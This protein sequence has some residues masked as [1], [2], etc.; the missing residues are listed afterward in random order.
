MA[1]DGPFPNELK[2]PGLET[3]G[4][5]VACQSARVVSVVIP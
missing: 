4:Q 1:E 5:H 3:A 2:S